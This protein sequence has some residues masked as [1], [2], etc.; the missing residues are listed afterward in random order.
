MADPIVPTRIIPAAPPPPPV[1]PRF[2][3]HRPAT[4]RPPDPGPLDVHV[5]VDV[6]L[7]G[8]GPEPTPSWWQR[9][10]IRWVY[11]IGC[12]S[13]A[14]PMSGPWA[15]VLIHVRDEQSLAGAWVFAVIPLAVLGLLD[16]ARRVEAAH[17]APDLWGPRIRAALTRTALWAA[18][19]ATVTALPIETAVYLLT[20]VR[21]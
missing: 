21:P 14:L 18:V 6:V 2:G 19:I 3:P 9:L 20:G 16:N 8:A 13:A 15:A 17:A 12:A 4:P 11:N 10:R 5:T 1:P 7:P